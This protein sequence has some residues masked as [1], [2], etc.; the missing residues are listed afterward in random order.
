MLPQTDSL[1]ARTMLISIG[2]FDPNLGAG[3]GVTVHDDKT[4]IEESA[5]RFREAAAEYLGGP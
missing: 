3:F 5:E 4:A 2:V 1:L